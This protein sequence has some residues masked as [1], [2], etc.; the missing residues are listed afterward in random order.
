MK[1]EETETQIETGMKQTETDR[2]RLGQTET[3]TLRLRE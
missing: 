2:F 3:D 1:R